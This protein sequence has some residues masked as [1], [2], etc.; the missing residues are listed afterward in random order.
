MINFFVGQQ[1]IFQKLF[2]L[3]L[4]SPFTLKCPYL[5]DEYVISAY[6]KNLEQ[7]SAKSRTFWLLWG[8]EM[9]AQLGMIDKHQRNLSIGK[10]PWFL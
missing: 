9:K 6:N 10:Q 1:Y 5:N 7:R 3:F 4:V 8:A 2:Q